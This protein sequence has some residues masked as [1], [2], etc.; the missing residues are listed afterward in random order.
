MQRSR[1][2]RLAIICCLAVMLTLVS[3][4]TAWAKP[5]P[6]T[7]KPVVTKLALSL[8]GSEYQDGDIVSGSVTAYA[9]SGKTWTPISGA[10][11]SLSL[12][13]VDVDSITTDG[14][15]NATFTVE[16]GV[17][18][19]VVKVSLPA[20][21]SHKASK[22]SRGFDVLGTWY[23]DADLDGYGDAGLPV[24]GTSQPEGSTEDD[25]DCNDADAAIN[26]GA[27]EV[28]DNGVDEDCDGIAS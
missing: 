4:I 15:G 1:T 10:T 2:H 6:K 8:D 24:Q 21:S 14:S 20:S 18:E 27:T 17:G 3:G 26:P 13:H 9:R 19:H 25:T 12:D 22:R 28:A 7:P 16:T 11:L 5:K 23:T